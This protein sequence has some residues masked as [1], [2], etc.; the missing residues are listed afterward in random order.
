LN[1]ERDSSSETNAR[2][3]EALVDVPVLGATP[4]LEG[5]LTADKLRALI[6]EHVDVDALAHRPEVLRA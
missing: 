5:E 2:L 4:H 1:G 6:D 3:I